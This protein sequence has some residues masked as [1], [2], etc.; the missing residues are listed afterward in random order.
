MDAREY[1]KSLIS[2]IPEE[3]LL[4]AQVFLE[5]LIEEEDQLTAEQFAALELMIRE[6]KRAPSTGPRLLPPAKK[7]DSK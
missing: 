6:L 3:E 5:M 1:L 2:R 4:T 7:D